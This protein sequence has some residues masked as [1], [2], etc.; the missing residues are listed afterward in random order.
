MADKGGPSR[1]RSRSELL[2]SP[3]K[4]S[5]WG[6]FLCSSSTSHMY[7]QLEKTR[8][9]S[10]NAV[11][12]TWHRLCAV[13][14]RVRWGAGH[15]YVVGRRLSQPGVLDLQQCTC[16]KNRK[17]ARAVATTGPLQ[18]PLGQISASLCGLDSVQTNPR[19]DAM[20]GVT[21][22]VCARALSQRSRRY[23][24]RVDA[25][26]VIFQTVGS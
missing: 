21:C 14:M 16:V 2:F 7:S 11:E 19:E 23:R 12:T 26:E 17:H 13:V 3:R 5:S 24:A 1:P 25:V 10:R 15:L 20:H 9:T 4:S 8:P 6:R 22:T 18:P